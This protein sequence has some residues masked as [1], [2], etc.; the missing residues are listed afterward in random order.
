M[1]DGKTTLEGTSYYCW[2]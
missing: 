1:T 2:K